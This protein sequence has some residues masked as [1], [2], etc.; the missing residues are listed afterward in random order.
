MS[1]YQKFIEKELSP[2]KQYGMTIGDNLYE[3]ML[4]DLDMDMNNKSPLVISTFFKSPRKENTTLKDVCLSEMEDII[5][6]LDKF[7]QYKIDLDNN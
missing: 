7:E 3:K 5:Q 1:R 4:N 6:L 2:E